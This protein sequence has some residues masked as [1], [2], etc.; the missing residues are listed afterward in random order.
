MSAEGQARAHSRARQMLAEM[1]LQEL[2]RARQMSQEALAQILGGKQASVSKLEHRADMY[3]STL[4][5]YI[6][7]MGGELEI[8]ARFPDED[9]RIK[10][11]TDL[12]QGPP[13]GGKTTPK[14]PV[15]LT[16]RG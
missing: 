14:R 11:F 16:R 12:D 9:V 2:R 3:V 13:Q 4:R 6:E 15:T 10:Q 8:V 1:P 7:A 5:S